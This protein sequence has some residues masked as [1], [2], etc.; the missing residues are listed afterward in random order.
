MVRAIRRLPD[1]RRWP[2]GMRC[3][4]AVA[5]VLATALLRLLLPV[6]G[7]PYLIFIPVLM[8]AGFMLGFGPG[9]LATSSPCWWRASSSS[10]NPTALS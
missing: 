7:L 6:M 10:A 9:A 8:V 5:I 3:G 4:L 2:V 1:Y